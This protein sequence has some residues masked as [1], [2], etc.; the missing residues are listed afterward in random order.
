VEILSRCLRICLFDGV[1]IHSNIHTIRAHVLGKDE[2]TWVFEDE[3]TDIVPLDDY[4]E[5]FVRSF[6]NTDI[7]N[8]G[9]LF[10]LSVYCKRIV[11]NYIQVFFFL[12]W[13]ILYLLF[14]F[15]FNQ[16]LGRT[17]RAKL[18]MGSFAIYRHSI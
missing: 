11:S 10:E 5:F 14:R 9:L 15:L 6:L 16:E 2:R 1:N 12:F 7:P 8:L 4:S 13:I 3:I 17:I 18:W